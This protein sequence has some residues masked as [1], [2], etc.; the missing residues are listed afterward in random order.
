MGHSHSTEEKG[1]IPGGRRDGGFSGRERISSKG[2]ETERAS[3]IHRNALSSVGLMV[4]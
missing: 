4:G 2:L 3:D 1:I